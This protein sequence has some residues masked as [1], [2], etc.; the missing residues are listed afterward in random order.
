LSEKNEI[1]EDLRTNIKWLE[2]KLGAKENG[3]LQ[4]MLEEDSEALRKVV[5]RLENINDKL[6]IDLD[7]T[8]KEKGKI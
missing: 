2:N 5:F 1:I 6:N 3:I 7:K 8:K 4:C